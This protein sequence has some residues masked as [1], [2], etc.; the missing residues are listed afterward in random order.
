MLRILCLPALIAIL[1]TPL[2]S[3]GQILQRLPADSATEAPQNAAASDLGDI[4]GDGDLDL[5]VSTLSSWG[6]DPLQGLYL[7]DGSGLFVSAPEGPVTQDRIN[8]PAGRFF[9]MD[10]DGDQ[11]LFVGSLGGGSKLYENLGNGE[12]SAVSGAVDDARD[13]RQISFIDADL[14]GDLDIYASSRSG[15]D[16][17]F[18]SN[19]GGGLFVREDLGDATSDGGNSTCVEWADVDGDGDLDLFV[20]NATHDNWLYENTGA[21]EMRRVEIEGLTDV[22]GRTGGASWGD[23]DGDGDM[24]LYVANVD[25]MQNAHYRND[26]GWTFSRLDS[27]DHVRDRLSSNSS[28]TFD[29]DLDGDLDLFVTNLD[30]GDRLYLNDGTGVF[31][32][33]GFEYEGD[34]AN[35]SASAS[36][37]DLDGDGDADIHVATLMGTDSARDAIWQNQTSE[38][39]G[40][41]WVGF[42]LTRDPGGVPSIGSTVTLFRTIDG[43][44]RHST[45][46]LLASRGSS[47]AGFVVTFG[48]GMDADIDSARIDWSVGA[49]E[50][51]HS[52]EANQVHTFASPTFLHDADPVRP[53]W[54]GNVTV[55]IPVGIQ[56]AITDGSVIY[57]RAGAPDWDTADV[58]Q[59]V[60]GEVEF[61]I[62]EVFTD[63]EYW[64]RIRTETGDYVIGSEASPLLLMVRRVEPRIHVLEE[65][66]T[67]GT[68]HHRVGWIASTNDIDHALLPRYST[69]RSVGDAGKRDVSDRM[70]WVL[71][72]PGNALLRVGNELWEWMGDTPALQLDEY[73]T[74][75]PLVFASDGRGLTHA[76]RVV[77]HTVDPNQFYMSEPVYWEPPV[78]TVGTEPGGDGPV[79][80]LHVEI[81][82]LWPNPASASISVSASIRKEGIVW[83]EVYDPL[84]R[85]VANASSTWSASG[86]VQLQVR[87]DQLKPGT[88]FLRVSTEDGA[89]VEP[90]VVTH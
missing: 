30:G 78:S 66:R 24:D 41:N 10:G 83:A 76:Y 50:W 37:G 61:S 32:W 13:L 55:R 54:P 62:P 22:G 45:R 87:V 53:V 15:N 11:D 26:G 88:Y 19:V 86:S 16:N 89:A 44:S 73:A 1:F 31:V 18:L 38:S 29:V 23:Y 51:I 40:N 56:L 5:F 75:I 6:F 84:G 90:F 14:D 2:S 49:S 72:R 77:A 9:D 79:Q 82:S 27:G 63:I 57:R 20:C 12:W 21:F 7:N 35:R 34:S 60:P 59:S 39:M 3:R 81:E 25:T 48:L 64:L 42:R 52:P 28:H 58:T 80:P 4:D 33:D 65:V 74:T 68:P 46:P 85:M 67:L 36:I 47:L 71:Q 8:S 70:A 69:W 17:V 43:Q